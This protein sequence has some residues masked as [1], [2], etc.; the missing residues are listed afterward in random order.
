MQTAP[1]SLC[2]EYGNYNLAQPVGYPYHVPGDHWRV[3]SPVLEPPGW[4]YAEGYVP[5]VPLGLNVGARAWL[6]FIEP[7]QVPRPRPFLVTELR[8]LLVTRLGDKTP[9]EAV[10]HWIYKRCNLLVIT[11]NS[12][13]VPR[14]AFKPEIKGYALIEFCT[15]S[16]ATYALKL[17]DECTFKGRKV[18]ARMTTE[19]MA[20]A[21][22]WGWPTRRRRFRNRTSKKEVADATPEVQGGFILPKRP[23]IYAS[24]DVCPHDRDDESD[25][26]SEA[27][28][29]DD[30]LEPSMGT[31]GY[32][33]TRMVRSLSI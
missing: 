22:L 28:M 29:E 13:H 6:N 14:N 24:S 8:K 5:A 7:I 1:G 23:G 15:T 19:G 27:E 9:V 11:I 18:S 31:T 3:L 25:L 26:D 16:A 2:H 32:R 33:G 17:L 10:K 30:E 4:G 12:I 21:A 20:R